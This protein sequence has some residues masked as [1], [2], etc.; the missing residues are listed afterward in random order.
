MVMS[1]VV[2]G[3]VTAN[4]AERIIQGNSAIFAEMDKLLSDKNSPQTFVCANGDDGVVFTTIMPEGIIDFPPDAMYQVVKKA[5]NW[6]LLKIDG[7]Y[8]QTYME[9]MAGVID[10]LDGILVFHE[11]ERCYI[12]YW[13]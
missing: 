12:T 2:F 3:R 5:G 7:G 1:F 4:A 9:V 6:E 13:Q 11:N 8:G 10:G